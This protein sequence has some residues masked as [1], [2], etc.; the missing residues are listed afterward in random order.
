MLVAHDWGAPSR[1]PAMAYPEML[2]HLVIVN[3]P[4]P[5][6]S[7]A[8]FRPARAA[9]SSAYMLLLRDAKAERVLSEDSFARLLNLRF[10]GR[11]SG[12]DLDADKAAYW[13]P[14]SSGRTDWRAQLLPRLSALPAESGRPGRD[15]GQAGGEGFHGARADAG[16]L[17]REGPRAAAFR[18]ST[19]WRG[20]AGAK[21]VR[22]RTRRTGHGREARPV[23]AET[24]SSFRR[25]KHGRTQ[26][27]QSRRS[28]RPRRTE[29]GVSPWLTVTRAHRP[30]CQGDRRSAVDP[31]DP[32]KAKSGP[33]GTTIAHGFLTLS[34]LSH[35][36]NRPFRFDERKMG[37]NYALTRCASPRRSRQVSASAR[38]SSWRNT[39]PFQ[40][41]ACRIPGRFD[42]ARR[43]RQSGASW[44][45]AHA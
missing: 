8:S 34:L 35:R 38:G 43:R 17:G 29:I 4:H 40:T 16:A 11:E 18:C 13:R 39:K 32:E 24:A 10:D 19:A 37:I 33:F 45:S 23:N 1:G 36:S 27:T 31:Y 30:V 22:C 42:R 28:L 26:K 20:G 5:Y 41:T 12:P 3:S 21:V 6:P 25:G 2:S 14:G 15:Q 44:P 7:G 9:A